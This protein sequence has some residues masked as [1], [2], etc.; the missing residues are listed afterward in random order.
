MGLGLGCARKFSSSVTALTECSQGLLSS[1][2]DGL[3]E[4]IEVLKAML[5]FMSVDHQRFDS[6]RFPLIVLASPSERK[7]RRSRC[8]RKL[9]KRN[10]NAMIANENCFGKFMTFRALLDPLRRALLDPECSGSQLIF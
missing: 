4:R 3:S 5:T 7:M 1:K 10:G 8:M 6:P 2:S 9:A